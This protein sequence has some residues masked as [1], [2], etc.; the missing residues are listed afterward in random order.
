MRVQCTMPVTDPSPKIPRPCA[1]GG[2]AGTPEA[3]PRPLWDGGMC[4]CVL[5]YLL[6]SLNT[7]LLC[8]E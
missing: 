3:Q 1:A 6:I 5:V 7:L 8:E 2:A 4:A